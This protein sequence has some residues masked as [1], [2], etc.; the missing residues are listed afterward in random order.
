MV[1]GSCVLVQA[2]LGGEGRT[3]R[4]CFITV[5]LLT[6]RS[7]PT[8]STGYIITPQLSN[9]C[10]FSLQPYLSVIPHWINALAYD[11]VLTPIWRNGMQPLS[12]SSAGAWECPRPKGAVI[13]CCLLC[14]HFSLLSLSLSLPS[15]F[16]FYPACL[17]PRGPS[18]A[19]RDLWPHVHIVNGTSQC[20]C[21]KRLGTTLWRLTGVRI[22]SLLMFASLVVTITSTGYIITPQLSNHCCFSLQPYLS[23]IPHWI[24][25]LAYDVVLTPIWRNGTQPLS[26]SSAG[27]WE[28]P[29]PKG[30]VIDCCLLCG[31][32][33]PPFSLLL[34]LSSLPL[35]P[36]SLCGKTGP[37]TPRAYSKR[38]E[39]VLL[40]DKG[41]GRLYGGLLASE[42]LHY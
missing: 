23:V 14:G 20:F 30:A 27:A 8:V 19:K 11:V 40:P 1:T 17:L 28:R 26:C 4:W 25:A 15:L 3:R 32:F 2:L 34:L 35:T 21:R 16:F 7:Q 22:I 42:L 12:C 41:W 9:H 38:H 24:S 10:C 13:D 29:R 5:P 6:G 36:R 37:L 18:V 33:F 39:P 31:H